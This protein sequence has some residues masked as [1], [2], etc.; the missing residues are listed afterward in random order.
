[1]LVLESEAVVLAS[2]TSPSST[3]ASAAAPR[4]DTLRDL[5]LLSVVSYRHRIVWTYLAVEPGL[6]SG[7]VGFRLLF[8]SVSFV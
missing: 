3:S 4:V 2:S 8:D 5:M 7:A 6:N 1:M